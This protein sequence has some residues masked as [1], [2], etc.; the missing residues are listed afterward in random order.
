MNTP[1]PENYGKALYYPYIHVR[2]RDW[3]KLALLYWD[4]IRRIV[5]S[6]VRTHDFPDVQMAVD[7]GLVEDTLPADYLLAASERFREAIIPLL[8][9]PFLEPRTMLSEMAQVMDRRGIGPGVA[10]DREVSIHVEKMA[11]GLLHQLQDR[12]LARR[13]E[14]WIAVE[15]GVGNL[16]MMCLASEMSARIRSPLVTDTPEYASCG[17]YL[18]Y[19]DPPDP[20]D[21]TGTSDL[22]LRLGIN[23]PSTEHLSRVPMERILGHHRRFAAERRRFRQAIEEIQRAAATISDTNALADFLAE[24]AAEIR[25]ADEAHQKTLE[26]LH[27]ETVG[28]ALL[29]SCPTVLAST[30]AVVKA[31]G[32]A[33]L[34]VV[35]GGIA[36]SI[37]NWWATRR[38]ERRERVGGSPWHYLLP[39]KEVSR[40]GWN[41]A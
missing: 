20:A 13:T 17:E 2:D 11:R 30:A 8:D 24:K 9:H 7:E 21:V 23:L 25:V 6:S 1:V 33:G 16:Y 32:E 41:R 37:V 5:P 40:R 35:G 3:L 26:D 10:P 12:G 39:L 22:L 31:V 28:S 34:A 27:V 29:I 38:R 18:A 19:G 15:R 4:G 36:V 14:D